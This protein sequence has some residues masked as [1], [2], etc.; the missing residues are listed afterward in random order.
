MSERRKRS[1]NGTA[2]LST[3]NPLPE[4]PPARS[5]EEEEKR[6]IGLAMDV[7]IEQMRTGKAS[8]QIITHFLKLGSLKEQAELEKTRKEIA[9]LEARKRAIESSE[10]QDL[11]YQ[12]L[13]DAIKSYSG[14]DDE[15]EIVEDDI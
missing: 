15:W 5:E 13:M 12:E 6:A 11:K 2:E 9:L 14:K 8:S 4:L 1:P 10:N 3:R 7:A